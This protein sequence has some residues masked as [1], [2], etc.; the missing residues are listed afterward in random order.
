MWYTEL[1][2]GYR[3]WC[4]LNNRGLGINANKGLYEGEIVPTALNGAEAWRM[5]S[6]KRSKVTVLEMKCLKSLVGVSRIDMILRKYLVRNEV[7]MRAGIEKELASR[8][9]SRAE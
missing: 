2:W 1:M 8:A 5:R 4:V 6:S 3:A 9:A 7:H